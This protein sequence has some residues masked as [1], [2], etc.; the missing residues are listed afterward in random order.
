MNETQAAAGGMGLFGTL[1]YI[2][3]TI[4]CI[5]I[6]WKVLVKAGQPGWGCLIPFYNIFLWLKV[7]GRPGWWLILFFIPVAN[8]VIGI[9]M[10]IDIAK[11]FGKS[12]GFGVGLIFL[13]P[14]FM[15]M[16]AFD[17]SE[18]KAVEA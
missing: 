4:F 8:I 3:I 11:N 18:Y 5:I 1:I 2:A 9:I 16:L 7:A 14:I 15:A 6:M 17:S 12:T 10:T 13:S